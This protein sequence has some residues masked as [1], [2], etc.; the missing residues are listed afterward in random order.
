MSAYSAFASVYD[1]MQYDIDYS[2]WIHLLT[3]KIQ[4]YRPS[5]RSVLE[6]ACGTAT[7]AIGL[8]KAGYIL[9]GV[10]LSE[11]MLVM[12]NHKAQE[13][14]VKIKLYHQDLIAFNTKKR[15]DVIFSMCD[16]MNYVVE[17]GDLDKTFFNVNSHLQEEGL[18]IFDLSTPYKLKEI[19]GNHTFAETFEDEAY[20]W[21]NEF[22]EE[23][24]RL[25]FLLT[26]FKEEN[27]HYA[28]YE[29]YHVQR[30]Y[31][32]DDVKVILEP[33]FEILEI[34]DGDSFEPIYEQSHRVCF[35]C[36]KKKLEAI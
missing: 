36:R 19:I 27:G 29:E 5:A 23:T 4:F 3:Q 9:E 1:M 16:G 24:N 31:A 34:V 18:F 28:R 12:A 10:D 7:M 35:I 13:Q 15:Y 21:E 2:R 14:Q 17:D 33:H 25:N 22:H 20:I 32:I 8:S 6:L 30:A 26:L 11:D